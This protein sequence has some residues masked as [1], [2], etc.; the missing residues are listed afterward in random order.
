MR[1]LRSNQGLLG[2]VR[3]ASTARKH[4]ARQQ[5]PIGTAGVHISRR[6]LYLVIV[7][8]VLRA[9]AASTGV[10]AVSTAPLLTQARKPPC[11]IV[12]SSAPGRRLRRITCT[13]RARSLCQSAAW[14][15]PCPAKWSSRCRDNHRVARAQWQSRTGGPTKAVCHPQRWGRW[16]SGGL[17]ARSGEW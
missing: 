12:A 3:I 13:R 16:R 9:I 5:N 1:G 14:S 6:S 11:S 8:E 15:L 2:C 10:A 7:Q 17:P 4:I